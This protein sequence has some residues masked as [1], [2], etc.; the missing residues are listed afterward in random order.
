LLPGFRLA[1]QWYKKTAPRFDPA[2]FFHAWKTLQ[3]TANERE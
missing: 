3:E 1:G 2:R